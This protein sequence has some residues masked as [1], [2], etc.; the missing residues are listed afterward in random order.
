MDKKNV[1]D[2][3][4]K[5]REE[6]KKRKFSQSFDLIVNL[7]NVDL[8]K[9]EQQLDFFVTLHFARGKKVRVCALVGP[10]MVA[11]AKVACDKVIAQEE[12]DGYGKNK[13]LAKKLAKEFDFFIAQAN[14]M[15]KVAGAFGRFLGPKGRMPNP[16]A[17]CVVAPKAPLKPLVEKLQKTVKITA[18]TTPIVQCLVGNES[19]PDEEMADNILTV[20]DS[21]MHNLPG[22]EN[23]INSVFV[24]LTMGKPVRIK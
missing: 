23:N 7:K 16:K 8:K 6:S 12:F 13:K 5:A 19:M 11:D 22:E 20:Y 21:V 1:L 18:K 10:E 15:A 24:K 3:L 9:P 14:L 17:G 2:A 4:K